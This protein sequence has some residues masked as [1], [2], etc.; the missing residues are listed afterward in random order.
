LGDI[1]HNFADI[2]RLEKAL[3]LKP[4]VSLDDGLRRFCDWALAQPVPEDS[5]DQANS[6]LAARKLMG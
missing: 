4:Q 5:L 1:R 6:E 2:S 3:G